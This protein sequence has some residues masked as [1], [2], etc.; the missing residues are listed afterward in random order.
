MDAFESKKELLSLLGCHSIDPEYLRLSVLK[1]GETATDVAHYVSEN[2]DSLYEVLGLQL[3]DFVRNSFPQDIWE[4]QHV[5]I[6]PDRV[7][8]EG[9]DDSELIVVSD[10]GHRTLQYEG[11]MATY[12][13]DVS[14]WING[15]MATV[16]DSTGLIWASETAKVKAGGYAKVHAEQMDNL[17][18]FGHARAIVKQ[19]N[20]IIVRENAFLESTGG[21]PLIIASDKAQYLVSGG[22]PFIFHNDGARGVIGDAV[23]NL[24]MVSRGDGALFFEK[25]VDMYKFALMDGHPFVMNGYA[26]EEIKDL[27]VDTIIPRYHG[28]MEPSR[29]CIAEPLTVERL[30]EDLQLFL[31]ETDPLRLDALALHRMDELGVCQ[32]IRQH[33][34]AMVERGL[35]AD[36]LRNH[37]TYET[38]IRSNIHVD[39]DAYHPYRPVSNGCQ[40]AFGEVFLNALD[41]RQ[42]I[43]GYEKAVIA[44]GDFSRIALYNEATG[45][46]T[47]APLIEAFDESKA[48]GSGKTRIQAT[49]NTY[50][51]VFGESGVIGRGNA[52]VQAFGQTSVEGHDHNYITL[53]DKAK[54]SVDD[55]CCVNCFGSNLVKALGEAEIAE[56]TFARD[57]KPS[58]TA[59]STVKDIAKL[60]SLIAYNF[61]REAWKMDRTAREKDSARIKR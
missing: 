56:M 30:A 41:H 53:F 7:I 58:L 26:S 48:F 23:P 14:L 25:T 20:T 18:L 32:L 27:F 37:F 33:I 11:T 45:F 31:P 39:E 9:P 2:F 24:T 57:S 49:D 16:V 38:L 17:E 47:D 42:P 43:Y 10:N 54:A 61:S 50:V 12:Y 29:A 55:H 34:P 35:N 36:F 5:L 6:N 15:G 40:Y 51:A 60:G 52:Q 28:Q 59:D 3:C 4:A 46:G 21:T 22:T 19:A 44:G 1:S 8:H 13:G